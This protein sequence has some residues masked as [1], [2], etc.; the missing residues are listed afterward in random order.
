MKNM[1][2]YKNFKALQAP[3]RYPKRIFLK[4]APSN[5]K[6]ILVYQELVDIGINKY[7]VHVY[8]WKQ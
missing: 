3:I 1:C 2:E 6:K 7:F 5:E 4:L 8:F